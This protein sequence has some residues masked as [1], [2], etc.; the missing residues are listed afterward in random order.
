[1]DHKR[2]YKGLRTPDACVVWVEEAD[3]RR[4]RLLENTQLWRHA[5]AFELGYGGS[6]PAQLALAILADHLGKDDLALGL[7]QAFKFRV[8]AS[9]PRD[10]WRIT[11]ADIDLEIAAI[12]MDHASRRRNDDEEPPSGGTAA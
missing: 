9:L 3:G 12:V 11:S 4:R 1:M 7:H 8:V 2:T 10:N 6:G 5:D